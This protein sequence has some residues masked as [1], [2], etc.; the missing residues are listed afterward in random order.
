[1]DILAKAVRFDDD[2][3]WVELSDGQPKRLKL[4][5]QQSDSLLS[6]SPSNSSVSIAVGFSRSG[7]HSALARNISW[8]ISASFEG[9]SS[10]AIRAANLHWRKK[11]PSQVPP[12][13]TYRDGAAVCV[14]S[15][16]NVYVFNRGAQRSPSLVTFP[17]RFL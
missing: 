12:G 4:T 11:S 2:S 3:M 9:H 5:P 7:S 15:K 10:D 14:D 1:M 8:V 17:C 13:F 16:D 6:A